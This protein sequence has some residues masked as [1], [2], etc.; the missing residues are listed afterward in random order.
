ML[1]SWGLLLLKKRVRSD[2]SS[3]RENYCEESVGDWIGDDEK[4]ASKTDNPLY[5]FLAA[6][7][8]AIMTPF[9]YHYTPS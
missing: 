4:E 6:H 3:L 2:C 1:A 9:W 8:P 5:S 7:I